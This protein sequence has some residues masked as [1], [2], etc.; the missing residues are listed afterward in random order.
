MSLEF[1]RR[2]QASSILGQFCPAQEGL[3]AVI[4]RRSAFTRACGTFAVAGGAKLGKIVVAAATNAA[5]AAAASAL[6]MVR[7]P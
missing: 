5:I 7:F 4:G 6:I 3:V 1:V 2:K